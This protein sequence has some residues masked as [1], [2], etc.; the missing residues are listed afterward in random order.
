MRQRVQEFSSG[1][2]LW[3]SLSKGREVSK[4]K[5]KKLGHLAYVFWRTK[6]IGSGSWVKAVVLTG[7]SFWKTDG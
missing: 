4:G 7:G 2:S 3:A 5:W 1:R 6:D